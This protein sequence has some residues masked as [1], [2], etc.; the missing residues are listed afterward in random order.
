MRFL[1]RKNILKK[2]N[3][4]V[5]PR[6]KSATAPHYIDE[7]IKKEWKSQEM[8]RIIPKGGADMTSDSES[9]RKMMAEQLWLMYFNTYLYEHGIITEKERNLMAI[10]IK[11]RKSESGRPKRMEIK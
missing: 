10:Q 5:F 8:G 11:N 1:F 7:K 6:N 2:R 3:F 9:D 4:R